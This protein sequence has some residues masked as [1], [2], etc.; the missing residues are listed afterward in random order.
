MQNHTH[1]PISSFIYFISARPPTH[2]K[3]IINRFIISCMIIIIIIDYDPNT[4]SR[5]VIGL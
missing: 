3:K 1:L 2:T 4:N 5:W